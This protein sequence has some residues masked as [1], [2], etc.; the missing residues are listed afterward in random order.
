MHWGCKFK[1]L[2][3]CAGLTLKVSCV[4]TLL[5]RLMRGCTCSRPLRDL[6]TAGWEMEQA[7]LAEVGLPVRATARN[8]ATWASEKGTFTSGATMTEAGS[9]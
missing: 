4:L 2:S 6:L 1:V 7:R 3:N 5:L 9:A 8:T